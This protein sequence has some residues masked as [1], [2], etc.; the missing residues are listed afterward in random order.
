M[1]CIMG[2]L[3]LIYLLLVV[4]LCACSSSDE[5][6]FVSVQNEQI[7]LELKSSL[8]QDSYQVASEHLLSF[9]NTRATL[10]DEDSCREA[11]KLFVEDGELIQKQI[12]EQADTLD[13]HLKDS[14]DFLKNLSGEELASLSFIV[15]NASVLENECEQATRSNFPPSRLRSCLGAAIGLPAIG[16][17]G[18]GGVIRAATLRRA[19]FAIGKR[20]LGYIGVALMVADFY[21][22][23]RG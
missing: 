21:D 10:N 18:V 3:N 9:V 1:I 4:F 20:Y 12:L 6:A 13:E 8:S 19:L 14:L 15:Y 2:K 11:L 16:E 23:Y 22:C 5:E 7:S 17:I